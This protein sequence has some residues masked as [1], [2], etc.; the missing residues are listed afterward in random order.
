MCE[1]LSTKNTFYQANGANYLDTAL[2]MSY[3]CSV[4]ES[5]RNFLP[6]EAIKILTCTKEFSLTWQQKHYFNDRE[7][8]IYKTK[9]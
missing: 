8:I 3:L 1:K 9:P 7:K 2:F 4:K 5:G 6:H